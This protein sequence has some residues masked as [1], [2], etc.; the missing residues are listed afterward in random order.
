MRWL[1]WK[2]YRLNRLIL[3]VGLG[4]LLAPHVFAT[5]AALFH[6]A[7]IEQF[8][9]VSTGYSVIT[10]QL[11]LALLGGN[12][13]AGERADRSVEFL[14]CL[15]FSR[16]QNMISKLV[17]A[18]AVFATIS[19]VNLLIAFVVFT[20]PV[21]MA[22]SLDVLGVIAI[23]GVTSL[24]FFCVSWLFS[25]LLNSATYSAAIGIISPLVVIMGI[26]GVVWLLGMDTRGPSGGL[27]FE[28]WY[29]GICL[30]LSMASFVAGAW[31]YL[32]RVEP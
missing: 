4:L 2:E 23:I 5:I 16:V 25:S 15:P 1:I 29:A 20:W 32:R 6:P 28:Y 31:Y 11:L 18:P 3:F 21:T 27:F 14:A 9:H 19:S 24:T 17:L 13:I 26:Q 30:L 8:F 10:T 7:E 22:N 12:A